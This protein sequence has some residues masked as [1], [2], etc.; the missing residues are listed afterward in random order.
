M[1]FGNICGNIK[2]APELM[3]PVPK[4]GIGGGY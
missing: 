2:S 4:M 1:V 3:A